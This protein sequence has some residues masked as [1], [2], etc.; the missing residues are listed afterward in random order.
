MHLKRYSGPSVG[1]VMRRIREELGPEAVILHTR[2]APARGALRFVGGRGVEILAAVDRDR[3]EPGGVTPPSGGPRR[4][5]P[6][7]DLRADIADIKRLLV[8]LSGGRALPPGGAAVAAGLLAAGLEEGLAHAVVAAL[9]PDE[10]AAPEGALLE[11]LLSVLADAVAIAPGSLHPR[12]AA[13]A[14]VGPP[15]A[16]KSTLVAKL[17]AHAHLRGGAVRILS[18]DPGC[19]GAPSPLETFARILGVPFAPV[20]G[21]AALAR[22]VPAAGAR[23]ALDLLDTPGLGAGEAGDA[24][25]GA[26]LRA[27]R[28]T[29]VHAVLGATQKPA[30]A[31]PVLRRARALGATHLALTRL[32]ETRSP[33]S[34]L[35]VAREAGLP[36]SYFGTGRDVP[37]DLQPA[38]L[39]ELARRL[40]AHAVRAARGA[41]EAVR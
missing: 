33:G 4:A 26:L 12:V 27:A 11:A 10:L 35:E 39:L 40:A 19:L 38:S 22:A 7:D 5:A 14:V 21:P 16:G 17:A 6:G 15:G 3:A 8:R 1:D 36:L 13:V 41:G 30:D 23:S 37:D 20:D 18:A 34:V 29:E 2:P 24:A 9:P 32:D 31:V 25:L 28:P